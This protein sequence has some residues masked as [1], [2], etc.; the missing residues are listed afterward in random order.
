[1]EAKKKYREKGGRLS[2]GYTV[3]MFDVETEFLGVDGSH[4]Y[5]WKGSGARV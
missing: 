4:T 1:V 5:H 3:V 2:E